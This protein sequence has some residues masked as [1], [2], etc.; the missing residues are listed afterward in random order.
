MDT[1]IKTRQKGA[2]HCCAFKQQAQVSCTLLSIASLGL[3]QGALIC[4]I[5]KLLVSAPQERG[6]WAWH[7]SGSLG[8][9]A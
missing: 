8:D 5:F 7:E 2:K 9:M 1:L 6:T 3:T 4:N